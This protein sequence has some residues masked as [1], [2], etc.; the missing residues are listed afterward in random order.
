[1]LLFTGSRH[2]PPGKAEQY[3][4]SM[5]GSFIGHTNRDFCYIGVT[6]PGPGWQRAEDILY[7]MVAK[8]L[9]YPEEVEKQR[10]VVLLEE[11]EKRTDPEKAL[12]DNIFARS[13]GSH[14]YKNSIVGKESDITGFTREDAISFYGRTWTPS[15]MTVVM[16]GDV[17]PAE[18]RAAVEKT[19]GTLPPAGFRRPKVPSEPFQVI[20]REIKAE[21][22][23]SVGYAA[24]GWHIC[25]ASD[26][27]IYPLDVLGAVL[28]NGRGSR[29]FLDLRER[30]GLVYEISTRLFPLKDPGILM[31]VATLK[32]DD[33]GDFVDEVLKQVNRLKDEPVS[34]EELSRAIK[35]IESTHLINI[36]TAEGQA[37][38]LGY[39]ATVYGGADLSQYIHNI[40]KVTA[41][42]IRR[43]AQKYLGEGDYTLSEINPRNQQ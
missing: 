10:K 14:P 36:E 4:E 17:R 2:I 32:P 6:I 28:G 21:M 11:K 29:L 8:P 13:Y 9:F 39:W 19:F 15:N 34:D 23:V 38:S 30:E 24:M 22:P 26:D 37:F 42:D 20:K 12:I 35:E 27:D 5:G 31:I 7:D 18:A 3:I 25:A 1:H 40:R 16:V 33:T 41:Q 43:V